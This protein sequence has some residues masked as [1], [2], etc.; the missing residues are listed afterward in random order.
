MYEEVYGHDPETPYLFQFPFVPDQAVLMQAEEFVYTRP[1]FADLS[2]DERRA[3]VT[4]LAKNSAADD[5]MGLLG[6]EEGD[7]RVKPI[8]LHG[9]VT[10]NMRSVRHDGQAIYQFTFGTEP[11]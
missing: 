11:E 3:N 6:N 8:E 1:E 10:V 7:S 9:D 5:N 4:R 2:E